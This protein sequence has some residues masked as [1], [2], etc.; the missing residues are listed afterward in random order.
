[1]LGKKGMIFTR[2]RDTISFFI[3][4]VLAAFG[5]IPLLNSFKVIA[6]N[7]PIFMLNL[8]VS[9]LVW[10]IA[11]AGAYVFIDGIIEPQMHILHWALIVSGLVLLIVGLIP[12]LYSFKVIGFTVPFLGGNLVVYQVLI[13][14][15]GLLLGIAGPTMH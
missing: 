3:G 10:V 8:P 11:L 12:I 13:V 9:I 6:W 15:E 5:I 4:L 14:V 1:M 2:L 7:L